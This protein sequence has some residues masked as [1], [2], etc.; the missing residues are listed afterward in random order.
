MVDEDIAVVNDL[1]T[2]TLTQQQKDTDPDFIPTDCEESTTDDE[3]LWTSEKRN[4]FLCS[5]QL[6]PQRKKLKQNYD[7]SKPFKRSLELFFSKKFMLPNKH[8]VNQSLLVTDCL[9]IH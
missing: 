3:T 5:S 7:N 6:S 9:L 2:S 1:P 4:H 8:E